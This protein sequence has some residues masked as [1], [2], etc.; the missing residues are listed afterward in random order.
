MKLF[1]V[2]LAGK[3][4]RAV[5]AAAAARGHTVTGGLDLIPAENYPTFSRACDVNVPFDALIDF[6]R[7]ETLPQIV[8]LTERTPRPCVLAT[9]GYDDEQNRTVKLLSQR[10][11]VVQSANFCTGIAALRALIAHC[12]TLLPDFDV[13]IIE[14]HHNRKTDA[15]SGTAKELCNILLSSLPRAAT[16]VHGHDGPRQSG[17]IGVHAVRGGTVAGVHEVTFYGDN[18]SLTL[19]HTAQDRTPFASGAVIAAEKLQKAAPGL[20]TPETLSYS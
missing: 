13:E 18:E 7:P 5:C 19:M 16:E 9:T 11:P 12:A 1:I 17:E 2:G 14:R 4:G 20:Y 15:P 3:A 10:V 8:E 6:S